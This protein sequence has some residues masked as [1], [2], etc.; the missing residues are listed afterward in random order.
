[1]KRKASPLNRKKVEKV[2]E[3]HREVLIE[4]PQFSDNASKMKNLLNEFV[5]MEGRPNGYS[6]RLRRL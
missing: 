1:M 2:E 4:K 5:G 3:K 6:R